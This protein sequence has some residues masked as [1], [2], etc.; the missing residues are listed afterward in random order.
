[1]NGANRALSVN[2]HRHREQKDEP[3]QDHQVTAAGKNRLAAAL[4]V[5]DQSDAFASLV[6]Q[7]RFERQAVRRQHVEPAE[8]Q[9]FWRIGERNQ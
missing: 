3:Q 2:Y 8:A 6:G 1:M 5:A 4:R 7:A 9:P